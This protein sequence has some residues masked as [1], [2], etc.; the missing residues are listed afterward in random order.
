[1]SAMA[2]DLA[3]TRALA[4]RSTVQAFRRPH[5]LAPVL[6]LPSILLAAYS[7]NAAGAVDIPGFPPVHRFF[8]FVL[9]GAVV[10]AAALAGISGGIG[11]ATDV[12]LRFMDRL[13]ATPVP[14]SA[15][16]L[17]RLAGT[18]AWG[19]LGT[20]W[21]LALG[22]AFGTDVHG[23]VPGALLILALGA[24]TTLAIATLIAGIALHSGRVAV[25]QGLFPL[26]IVLMLVSSAFFPR[27]L[28]LQPARA[29]AAANPMSWIA[30]AMRAPWIG[31][32]SAAAI[33]A[34]LAA[35]AVVA[36]AGT[37]LCAAGFAH[38]DGGEA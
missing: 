30:E 18:T 3:A 38:R 11:L 6:V 2:F 19:A 12:E 9:A 16:V 4:R 29:I 22:L 13:L 5:F 31:D 35:I 7:G 10:L 32:G 21:F 17:G 8:D 14:R 33:P 23:G 28:L 27:H 37:A 34:G 24:L 25:V 20:A 36:A 26:A 1:M 15:I